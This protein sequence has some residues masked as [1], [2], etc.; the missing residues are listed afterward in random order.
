MLIN[1]CITCINHVI[2]GAVRM[3]IIIGI[4]GASG[5]IYGIR[6]LEELK[7]LNVETHLVMSK[8]GKETVITET[9]Y[10]VEEV[11]SLASKVYKEDDVSASISSGSF[12]TDGMVI[13]PCSMK[14]LS[15]IANGYD[16]GLMARAAGV[17]LKERRKLILVARE[18]P[19]NSI[20]LEN[21]LKLSRIG[22]DIMPPVPS[23][24]TR[25]KTI[26]DIVNHT[27][28]R[29]LDHLGID[30]KLVSR[31]RENQ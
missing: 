18:T 8:W 1:G 19:L 27:V 13:A 14:T 17:C 22:V 28:G 11:M 5:A 23:F 6:L 29:I 16:A 2:K 30:N 20:Q 21:M 12:K 3:K 26:N 15:A 10:S 25:P 24:Y 7:K 31:W 4:S 9:D